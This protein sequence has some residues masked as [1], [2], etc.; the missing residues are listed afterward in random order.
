MFILQPFTGPG[1]SMCNETKGD[2]I[3]IENTILPVPSC[4]AGRTVVDKFL[5]YPLVI[6]RARSPNVTHFIPSV[7]PYS[8]RQSRCWRRV[9]WCGTTKRSSTDCF[10]ARVSRSVQ[11]T[12]AMSVSPD[13]V[14]VTLAMLSSPES[15]SAF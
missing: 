10:T 12:V 13:P 7:Q 1:C 9:A 11:Y 3:H 15:A 5:E 14:H 2:F 6:A 4:F 8:P